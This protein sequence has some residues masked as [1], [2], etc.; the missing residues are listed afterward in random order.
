MPL[1]K[2]RKNI[3][4]NIKTEMSEGKS[5]PQSIAIALQVSRKPKKMAK[6]GPVSA[7]NEPRPMP[8]ETDNDSK[9]VSR[10]EG[11]KPLVQADWDSRPDIKQSQ[12]GPKTTRIKHPKMAGSGAF[13]VRLRDQEDDLMETASV[14]NGPQRQPPEMYDEEG[15]DRQGPDVPALHMKR[16]AKGGMLRDDSGQELHER[17][18]EAHLMSTLGP[19]GIH[20]EQP[21]KWRDELGPD[22]SGPDVPALHMKRMAKGGEID[23]MEEDYTDKPDKGHGAIIFK[24]EGGEVE[25]EEERHASL[26]AAVM[27]KRRKA[28]KG[29]DSDSDIEQM[30]AE[31]GAVGPG[32]DMADIE[33]ENNVE[34]PNYYYERN[35]DKALKENYDEDMIGLHQSEDS[36]LKGDD[37]PSD[38]HDHIDSIRRKMKAKRG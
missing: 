38:E 25:A 21:E 29:A 14:N 32:S 28:A 10:S 22:R 15:A 3:G 35:E 26:A 37:I 18:D 2:G 27:A 11:K 24:A 33:H 6:G 17:E 7:S 8:S 34:H 5:K 23:I 30:L 4:K 13:Q 36:N 9:M 1:L 31:G 20:D 12:K 16:M 19:D